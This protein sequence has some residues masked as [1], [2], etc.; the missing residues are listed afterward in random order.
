MKVLNTWNRQSAAN[1]KDLKKCYI[2]LE[3]FL[4]SPKGEEGSETR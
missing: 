1:P 3:T 2:Y 4:S